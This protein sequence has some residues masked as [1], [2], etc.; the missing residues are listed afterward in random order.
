MCKLTI[1]PTPIIVYGNGQLTKLTIPT[2][3]QQETSYTLAV[4]KST[5]L[6]WS[7]PNLMMINPHH[8]MTSK[9]MHIAA[10][11]FK[12]CACYFVCPCAWRATYKVMANAQSFANLPMCLYMTPSVETLP[13]W[14]HIDLGASATILYLFVNLPPSCYYL[15]LSY[16]YIWRCRRSTLCRSLMHL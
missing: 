3:A 5:A 13:V 16:I 4:E 8:T 9:Q 1:I 2:Q 14:R 10:A 15:R 7:D 11:Q 12:G 6:S